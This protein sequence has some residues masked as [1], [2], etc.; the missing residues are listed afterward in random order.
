MK[1]FAKLLYISITY[2]LFVRLSILLLILFEL[3]FPNV[4]F[5]GFQIFVLIALLSAFIVPIGYFFAKVFSKKFYSNLGFFLVI[6]IAI[7]IIFN[8][9]LMHQDCA[10]KSHK[11]NHNTFRGE[12]TDLAEVKT[13]AQF[14]CNFG[15]NTESPLL[16]IMNIIIFLIVAVSIHENSKERKVSLSKNKV[17]T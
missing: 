17:R 7:S 4:R 9:F 15:H 16:S 13:Y 2:W 11:H 10:M 1:Q 8:T 14:D 3:K 5:D 12:I 6:I